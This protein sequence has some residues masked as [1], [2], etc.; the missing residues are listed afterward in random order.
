MAINGVLLVINLYRMKDFYPKPWINNDLDKKTLFSVNAHDKNNN[1]EK[2]KAAIQTADPEIMLIMEVIDE[3]HTELSDVF[4]RY[5]YT[6]ETPVR[7]GFRIFLLSKHKMNDENISYHGQSNSPFLQAKFN[8]DNH[9]FT[10]YSGHPKPSF[11]KKWNEDRYT[12]FKEIEKIIA[13]N[14]GSKIIMGDFNTVPWDSRFVKFLK[15]INMRSTLI[16]HGYKV[17]WPSYFLPMGIPMDHIL[18]SNDLNYKDLT[19]GP[20][21]GSDH[22]PISINLD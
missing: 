16:N 21:V 20:D 4:A 2:L 3:I 1:L 9:E 7:D 5:P 18:I 19:V 15:T 22:Y 13:R 10:V 6:L 17:T 11:N 8:I 14:T 12:Y